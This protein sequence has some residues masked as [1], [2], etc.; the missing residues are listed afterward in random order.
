MKKLSIKAIKEGHDK[1]E[2]KQLM[3]TN[4]EQIR[5]GKANRSR[6]GG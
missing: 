6:I 1:V 4:D 5:L 3:R 2:V